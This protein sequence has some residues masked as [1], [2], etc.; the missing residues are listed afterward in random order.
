MKDRH[1]FTL[2]EVI[3]VI[4]IIALLLILSYMALY[5]QI[6]KGRDAKRK[7]DINYIQKALEE[8][9]KDHNCYLMSLPACEP[10]DGLAPYLDK[11]PCAPNKGESYVYV[12]DPDHPTCP[13]WYWIFS[14]FDNLN[15]PEIEKLGCTNKCGPSGML[16]YDYYQTSP[17]APEP[18]KGT[19]PQPTPGPACEPDWYGCKNGVCRAICAYGGMPECH[20]N[21]FRNPGCS[22]ECIAEDGGPQNECNP[23]K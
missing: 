10:G 22:D 12:A 4:T 13:R 20:P 16:Y 8:S 23:V 21:Y 19:G 1:G 6:A 17:N 3:I 7:S 2:I 14:K 18:E 11:I 15:D 9:E 5:S